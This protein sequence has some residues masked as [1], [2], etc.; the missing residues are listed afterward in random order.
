MNST[1]RSILI[2]GGAGFIGQKLAH[3][4]L[5]SGQRVRI[6]DNFSQQVHCGVNL[7][8]ELFSSAEVINANICDRRAVER[9]IDGV[10]S[11]VHLAAETGTGQSMYEIARYNNSNSQGTAVLLDVLM[12]SRPSN[13]RQV[14]LASSRAVYGEGAYRCSTCHAAGRIFPGPRARQRLLAG[15]W[16]PQCPSCS[17]SLIAVPTKED[18]PTQPISI[19][20]ATKLAQENLIRI[21]CE[22]LSLDYAI[23]R[24]QNVYG[25]G[26][27][28]I[29]PYTGILSIFS[30]RIQQGLYLPIFEDGAGSR[31]FVH[32][33][34]VT[35]VMIECINSV[36]PINTIINVGSGSSASILTVAKQ[37]VGLFD[38]DVPVKITSEHRLGDIRHNIADITRLNELFPNCNNV[39]FAE[40]LKRFVDWVMSQPVHESKLDISSSE[41]KRFNLLTEV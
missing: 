36:N 16:D 5:K 13:L 33:D 32:V 25:E 2:T 14:I 7:P 35:Q 6:I 12:N 10:E 1:D 29:N 15:A 23:L 27:S 30:T 38:V 4:L 17:H 37:L 28:L 20:A 26:Q 34:D 11:I 18:D 8:R 40:G 3:K 22:A 31:D 24:L 39:K 19:Y 9:A 41:L 21:A